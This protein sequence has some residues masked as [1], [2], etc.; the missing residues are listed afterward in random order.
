MMRSSHATLIALALPALACSAILGLQEPTVDDTIDG[1]GDSSGGDV[2][3]GDATPDAPIDSPCGADLQT[4]AHNCGACGRDCLGSTCSAGACQPTL[5]AQSTTI[6]PYGLALDNGTLYFTNVHNSD[7]HSVGKVDA[8]AT[9]GTITLLVDYGTGYT[10]PLVD[11]VVWGLAV[12]NGFFYTAIYAGGGQN[13]KWEAGVD[14]CP[15]TGCTGNTLAVYGDDSYTI[16]TN[17]TNVFWGA[18]DT[19]DSYNVYKAN[20]DF[21]GTTSIA[22]PDSE[23]NGIVVDGS[24]LFF[25]TFDGVFACT[26]TC[27]TNAI[28]QGVSDAEL[29]AVDA[30][31]VYYSSTQ[32]GNPAVLYVPKTGGVPSIIATDVML[33][34]GV[35]VD[36]NYVYFADI[37]DT[38]NSTTGKVARCPKTGCSLGTETTLSVGAAA[39]DN[40]REVVLDSQYVYWGTRGGKIW[41]VAK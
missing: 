17:A 39:G 28:T 3:Q 2:V 11:G 20:L 10:T 8:S 16:A 23:V 26:P 1:G 30:N 41:R 27:A 21:T 25:G 36:D 4:D 22:T 32:S 33:P 5:V 12:Q 19:N 29:L 14:R 6:S 9:N 13:G 24:N 34:N 31:N 35:A 37:G 7:Y 38:A 40:P 15:T 18:T